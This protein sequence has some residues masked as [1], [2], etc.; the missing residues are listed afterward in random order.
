MSF[1]ARY[2]GSTCCACGAPILVGETIESAVRGYRHSRNC[3]TV[4]AQDSHYLDDAERAHYQ[5]LR[6]YD[7]S[8]YAK[9]IADGE[10]YHQDRVM[11]GDALADRW[12]MDEE[13]A[14]YNRGED[15]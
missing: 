15:Y 4:L 14:R 7:N 5:R 12:A 13:L 10:R 6:D 2:P 1:K 9:G 3:V 11:F 8:E